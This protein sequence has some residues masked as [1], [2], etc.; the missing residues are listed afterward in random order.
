MIIW[1][2]LY[3]LQMVSV[4]VDVEAVLKILPHTR[5][6]ETTVPGV[7]IAAIVAVW[8]YGIWNIW[9]SK[10]LYMS[11]D[12]F[13]LAAESHDLSQADKVII[14]MSYFPSWEACTFC[15]MNALNPLR[16]TSTEISR[17]FLNDKIDQTIKF[18]KL[19]SAK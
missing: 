16:F 13:L 1:E 18:A 11:F 10:V 14:R 6:L 15:K 12:K 4:I 19:P 7:V 2:I 17:K 9:L 3:L 8:P 5:W